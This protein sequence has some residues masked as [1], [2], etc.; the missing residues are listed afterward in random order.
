MGAKRVEEEVDGTKQKEKSISLSYRHPRLPSLG[1]V[2]VGGGRSL[3]GLRVT[4]LI[5]KPARSY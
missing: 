1:Q 3:H 2:H 4:I 5:T